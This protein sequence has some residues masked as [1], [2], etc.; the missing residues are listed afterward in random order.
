MEG[1]GAS[2]AGLGASS[3]GLRASWEDLGSQLR[4]P[5]SQMRGPRSQLRGPRS[6][7]RGPWS[8]LGGLE[9]T[10]AAAQKLKPS[11][12]CSTWPCF[13]N[14]SGRGGNSGRGCFRAYGAQPNCVLDVRPSVPRAVSLSISSVSIFLM[15]EIKDKRFSSKK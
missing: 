4:W 9:P 7:L 15:S 12:N 10:G 13:N 14:G 6:Q 3:E 2:W 1:L 11:K 8:Q 5:R